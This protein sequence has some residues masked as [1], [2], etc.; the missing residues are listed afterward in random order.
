MK[1]F[2]TKDIKGAMAYAAAG[3]QALHMM[4]GEWAKGWGGP[5]CFRKAREFAHLFDQNADRLIGTA[6]RLGVRQVVVS[7]RGTH[8]QHVDLCGRPLERAK[9]QADAIKEPA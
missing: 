2:P 7:E 4:T 6:R 5:Q 8:R 1:L 9:A 3:R